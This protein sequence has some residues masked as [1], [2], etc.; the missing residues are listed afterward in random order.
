MS[1]TIQ[2]QRDARAQAALI[3]FRK[4][5]QESASAPPSR[6]NYI[7]HDSGHPDRSKIRKDINIIVEKHGVK[8]LKMLRNIA[9]NILKNVEDPDSKFK[10]LRLET[11]AVKKKIIRPEGVLQV[12]IDMGFTKVVSLHR[13]SFDSPHN[14][15]PNIQS[16]VEH[17]EYRTWLPK[18][19]DRLRLYEE[20]LDAAIIE[21]PINQARRDEELQTK[22]EIEEKEDSR[23]KVTTLSLRFSERERH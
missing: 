12:V 13:L 4:S 1:T 5:Q 23:Q 17:E 8:S 10:T 16:V 15:S 18:H 6:S 11:D 2:H 9:Q 14:L 3:R 7:D 19:H 22:R 20:L 21:A